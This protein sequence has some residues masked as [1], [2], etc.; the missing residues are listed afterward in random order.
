MTFDISG[1]KFMDKC[2]GTFIKKYYYTVSCNCCNRF[3]CHGVTSGTK[4]D[5]LKT[6]FTEAYC[7][8]HG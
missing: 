3:V 6:R 8:D 4:I 7:F 2:D 5:S 1:R